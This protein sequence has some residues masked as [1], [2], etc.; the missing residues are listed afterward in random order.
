MYA[1][2]I[3]EKLA[4]MSSQ[5]MQL[6]AQITSG[7]IVRSKPIAAIIKL[8]FAD[9]GITGYLAFASRFG[10]EQ[11]TFSRIG[12]GYHGASL[13]FSTKRNSDFSQAIK[14]QK[15]E[16]RAPRQAVRWT[17]KHSA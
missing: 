4:S 10:Q 12:E 7:T 17:K 3:I 2:P 5:L 16:S 1:W 11:A 13:S 6:I 8:H 15:P 9:S 14:G